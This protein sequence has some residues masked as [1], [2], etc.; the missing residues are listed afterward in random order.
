M[1][2]PLVEIKNIHKNFG[3]LEVLKGVD[4]S[5]NQGEVVCL[6]GTSGSGKSTLL[7]CINL[8]EIPDSG[9]IHVFGEDVLSIKN[10]NQFRKRVGMC[11]QQFNLFGNYSVIDNCIMP[12]LKVLKVSKQEATDTAMHYLE[13]VGMQ[14][15]AMADV[16]RLSGGQ[17]QRVALARAM[18]IDPEI[19]GYD[20]PTSA[21]DPELRLEVEKLILQNK[22][23]GM[24]QIVVTHDLQF[25]E[26][27]ADQILKVEPK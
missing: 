16:R 5:V 2:N 13:K 9:M 20:E 22:E 15:F 1:N 21:L 10:V 25:A 7:R 17:K 27:I 3:P 11:F 8:L 14:D 24:T 19:I 12:Q 18:M 4:F 26:N 6:I 23:R